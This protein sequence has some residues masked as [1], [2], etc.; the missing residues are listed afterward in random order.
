MHCLI[1][2]VFIVFSFF[3]STVKSQDEYEDIYSQSTY[4]GV[5]L[6]QTPTARF[7]KDGEFAFGIS[8]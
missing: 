2:I 6:I 4:G 5:G 1:I 8:T 7:S 3:T